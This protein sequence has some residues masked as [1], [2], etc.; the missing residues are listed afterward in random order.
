MAGFPE[1]GGPPACGIRYAGLGL[2]DFGQAN[3]IASQ[4]ANLVRIG[5]PST[6]LPESLTVERVLQAGL[7]RQ[8]GSIVT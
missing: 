1:F 4:L 6:A 2:A 7:S 8:A 5:G 3:D